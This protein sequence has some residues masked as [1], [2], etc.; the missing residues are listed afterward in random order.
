MVGGTIRKRVM[1]KYLV[2]FTTQTKPYGKTQYLKEFSAEEL[3][4]LKWWLKILENFKHSHYNYFNFL[5]PEL[6]PL[7]IALPEISPKGT[8]QVWGDNPV[9]GWKSRYCCIHRAIFSPYPEEEEWLKTLSPDDLA[10]FESFI[11]DHH[12]S[13]GV[14]FDEPILE[15]KCYPITDEAISLYVI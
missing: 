4:K 5:H 1:E 14:D 6:R 15:V 7:E 3:R 10:D 12:S 9:K 2:V 8:P 11:R 13:S